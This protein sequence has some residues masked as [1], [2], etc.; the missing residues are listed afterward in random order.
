MTYAGPRAL[1]DAGFAL[2]LLVLALLLAGGLGRKVLRWFRLEGLSPLEEVVFSLPL[3]LGI[4]AY[5][6]MALGLV[7]VLQPWAILVLLAVAGACTWPEWTQIVGG[8]SGCTKAG[9]ELW[10]RAGLWERL[11]LVMTGLILVLTLLQAL[12]PPWEYDALM[13]HLQGPREFLA[14]GRILLLPD[15]WPANYPLTIQMLFTVGLAF[16]SSTFAKLVHLVYGALLPL[17]VL[18]FA[19]RY[20][21]S[22][23]GWVAAA[24]LVGIPIY[25]IW[26]GL[27]YADIAW[28][29]YEFLGLYACSL[30]VETNRRRWLGLSGLVIGLA[31]GSKYLALGGAAVLGLWVLWRGRAHGWKAA[32]ASATVF[33]GTALLVGSPWYV[34]NWLWAGN[35]V[36][37]WFFGGAGWTAERVDWIR[38]YHG[39]FSAGHRLWDYLLLPWNL[40]ARHERFGTFKG[41]IEVPSLLFPLALLYPWTRR[42]R[43]MN[44]VAWITLLRFGVWALGSQQ[45]R[46]LLPVFPG[47]SLLTAQVLTGLAGRPSLRRWGRILTTG[48][49]AGMV[50][51]TLLY[52]IFFFMDIRPLRV[53][54][55]LESKDRFLRRVVHDYAAVQYVQA[56]LSA[57]ERAMLMWDAQAFYCDERCLPDAEHSLWTRLALADLRVSSVAARLRGRGVTHLLFSVPD[58]DFI[59]QHDPTG[60]HRRAAEFFLQEFRE[61]CAREIYRDDWTR[62]FELTCR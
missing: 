12:A 34:K 61:S 48:L 51:A 31:L 49:T 39:S 37:P 46:H 27:A 53:V 3:G 6:V 57:Q 55:G 2:G 58:V 14:A 42:S 13:Y 15:N 10:R 16:G 33:G 8:L 32:L 56:H 35:P 28:A 30:W 26:A 62:L 19:R 11:V 29:L 50:A 23:P 5:A 40:Y 59:L 24:I 45:T 1:L 41:S 4:L 36:F 20:L 22:V 17:G 21:Q 9:G 47:L 38:T 43:P 44:D 7:G 60:D 25:P 18:A 52:S 54:S